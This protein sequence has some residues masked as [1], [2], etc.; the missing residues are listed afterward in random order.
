MVGTLDSN[1]VGPPRQ[2]WITFFLVSFWCERN[3]F[4]METTVILDSPV[5]FIYIYM[6]IAKPNLN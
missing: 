6:Y 5:I 2:P 1:V 4:L 3:K